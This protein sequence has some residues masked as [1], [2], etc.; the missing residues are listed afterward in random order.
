MSSLS[1]ADASPA[2][3]LA[4]FLLGGVTFLY[5][6]SFISGAGR[7]IA[8]KIPAEFL[9]LL[10]PATFVAIIV[11]S[12]L[13]SQSDPRDFGQKALVALLA[14]G[15]AALTRSIVVTLVFGLVALYVLQ[16]FF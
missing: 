9:R 10:A 7:K 15:V 13:A 6:Y 16:N 4:V 8:A 2:M 5:R 3:L 12:L 11:N 1:V 14:F